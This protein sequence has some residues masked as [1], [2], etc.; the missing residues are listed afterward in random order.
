V[1]AAQDAA[2]L[3]EVRYRSGVTSY[4]EVLTNETNA[5]NA[6][7]GLTQAQLNELLELVEIY[8]SL[9]GGWEP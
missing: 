7:L 9:G 5:F 4:L 1:R 2:Q 8:R 3:A 6:E